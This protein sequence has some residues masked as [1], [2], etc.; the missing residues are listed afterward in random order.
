MEAELIALRGGQWVSMIRVSTAFCHDLAKPLARIQ[1]I[2]CVIDSV[3]GIGNVLGGEFAGSR[4]L[5]G[6]GPILEK[7]SG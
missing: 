5:M 4:R 1:C 2:E 3:T 7:T 6:G